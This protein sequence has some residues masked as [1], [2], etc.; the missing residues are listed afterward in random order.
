MGDV[1]QF[2]IQKVCNSLLQAHINGNVYR[3][4]Y[5]IDVD[6]ELVYTFD[7][8][9]GIDDSDALRTFE[10]MMVSKN[11]KFVFLGIELEL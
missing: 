6:G 7:H 9:C 11:T 10:I 3:I 8:I 5:M 1:V 4:A 2:P